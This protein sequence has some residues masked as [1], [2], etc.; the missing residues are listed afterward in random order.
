MGNISAL[1][2]RSSLSHL[3]AIFS[4]LEEANSAIA[5]AKCLSWNGEAAR[6]FRSSA[7]L[8]Q[9]HVQQ[10]RNRAEDIWRSAGQLLWQ[11]GEEQCSSVVP[12]NTEQAIAHLANRP[13]LAYDPERRPAP[14]APVHP[15]VRYPQ[16]PARK[17][18][19]M[20]M[21]AH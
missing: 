18:S 15:S 5:Q 12:A 11:L 7:D 2:L 10:A 16:A 19:S 13:A 3:G 14:V 9:F 8:V 17:T 21:V 6:R 4:Q 20:N 1:D